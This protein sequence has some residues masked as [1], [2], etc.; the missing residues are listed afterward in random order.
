MIVV[1][2]ITFNHDPGAATHDALNL[3]KNASE[4]VNL[5]EWR[6]FISVNPEDSPAAYAFGATKGNTVTIHV[7]LRSTDPGMAF[8]EIRVEHHVAARAVNFVNGSTGV[9][10]F[11]LVDPPAEPG[12]V[13]IRDVTWHWEFRLGP[14]HP[15][16][17]FDVTRQR[18]RGPDRAVAADAIQHRQ[19]PAAVDRCH[20]LRLPLGRRRDLYGY[21]G[22]DGHA[23]GLHPR[24][25]DRHL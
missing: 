14:R 24:A 8:V 23:S 15:W 3:R 1:E 19:H 4:A 7:V 2:A 18:A 13:G 22:G 11:E 6:R 16:H 25:D 21:G 10:A 20:G 5:P 17:L 12:Q 9:V